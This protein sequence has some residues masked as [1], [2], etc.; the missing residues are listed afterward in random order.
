MFEFPYMLLQFQQVKHQLHLVSAKFHT[1]SKLRYVVKKILHSMHIGQRP[2]TK[3]Y[4]N[5]LFWRIIC[6]IG[7]WGEFLLD[8]IFQTFVRVRVRHG[9]WFSSYHVQA[10]VVGVEE[11]RETD[12]FIPFT[13]YSCGRW[14]R[15]NRRGCHSPA[16][17]QGWKLNGWEGSHRKGCGARGRLQMSF[18]FWTAVQSVIFPFSLRGKW[19]NGTTKGGKYSACKLYRG[20]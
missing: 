16:T 9:Q 6:W 7:G 10:G 1:I 8:L 11:K 17:K 2:T 3:F 20:L 18:L 19:K 12:F 14:E 5:Y 15:S 4:T 13:G